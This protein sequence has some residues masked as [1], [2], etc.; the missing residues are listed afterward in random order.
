MQEQAGISLVATERSN[1]AHRYADLA[2]VLRSSGEEK[3]DPIS[4]NL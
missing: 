4:F 2:H 1:L 3:R